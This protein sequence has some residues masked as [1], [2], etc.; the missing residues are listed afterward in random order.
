[1][2]CAG[3]GVAVGIRHREHLAPGVVGIPRHNIGAGIQNGDDVPLQVLPE[4]IP[5]SVVA[6]GTDAAAGVVVIVQMVRSVV[7]RLMHQV[8]RRIP[9]IIRILRTVIFPRPQARLII[10]I[11]YHLAPVL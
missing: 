6:N 8:P 11:R 7:P 2:G 5:Y 10:G 1:M 3:D 9:V 4:S